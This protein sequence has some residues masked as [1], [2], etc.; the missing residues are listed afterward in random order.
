[1]RTSHTT[2]HKVEMPVQPDINFYVSRTPPPAGFRGKRPL[3][4]SGL[5][6]LPPKHPRASRDLMLQTLALPMSL[7]PETT[8]FLPVRG[9]NGLMVPWRK[10]PTRDLIVPVDYIN[11]LHQ[12]DRWR[13]GTFLSPSVIGLTYSGEA[14]RAAGLRVF[15]SVPDREAL[16]GWLASLLSSLEIHGY[17]SSYETS[18]AR[19]MALPGPLG[20]ALVG[21]VRPH[22]PLFA[23]ACV[24][25]V[26]SEALAAP[27][28]PFGLPARA[29]LGAEIEA[30]LFPSLL[31]GRSPTEQELLRA[32]FVLQEEFYLGPGRIAD[33]D[34]EW[35]LSMAAAHAFGVHLFSKAGE[36]VVRARHMWLTE[37]DHPKIPP[38][39]LRPSRLRQL[40]AERTGISVDMFMSITTIILTVLRARAIGA[41]EAQE[42]M[43]RLIRK[44]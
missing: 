18:L 43:E 27:P 16:V 44:V 5:D 39:E 21:A 41:A 30:L 40:F 25:W 9:I 12:R 10:H 42:L 14:L 29:S 32:L 28:W 33:V 26:L 37:D 17:G 13:V 15:A 3:G 8:V 7:F 38:R 19:A 11:E 36:R 6:I 35:V 23:P 4:Y 20:P 24:R 34:G 2:V 22:T 31:R 1:M